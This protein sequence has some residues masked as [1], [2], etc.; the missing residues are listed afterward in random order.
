M[1][2]FIFTVPSANFWRITRLLA[3]KG[4]ANIASTDIGCEG[5]VD[6]AS[7]LLRVEFNGGVP[8]VFDQALVNLFY[9]V[10]IVVGEGGVNTHGTPGF[11]RGSFGK[12]LVS[13][14]PRG[15]PILA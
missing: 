13:E 10:F 11:N 12:Q 8:K 5:F 7:D 4:D 3:N 14:I 2:S 6:I 15:L 1:I 9:S